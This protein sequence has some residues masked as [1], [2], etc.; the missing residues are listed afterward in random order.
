MVT[1]SSFWA[2]IVPVRLKLLLI[3]KLPPAESA[4]MMPCMNTNGGPTGI[5]GSTATEFTVICP[6]GA[7]DIQ[8]Y[9]WA[10]GSKTLT[11]SAVAAFPMAILALSANH[12]AR[13][14]RGARE[15]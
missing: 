3:V 6:P 1:V 9:P 12:L 4:S 14:P 13:V 10:K 11:K 5:C 15:H 2:M 8:R 7:E